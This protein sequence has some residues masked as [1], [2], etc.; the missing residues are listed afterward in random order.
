MPSS[1]MTNAARRVPEHRRRHA[2]GLGHLAVDVGQQR[3]GQA[4]VRGERLV[5]VEV[6]IGDPDDHRVERAHVV[7]AVAV[8]AELLG[9]D[10]G[11]VAGVEQ[12]HDPLARGARRAGSAPSVPSSVEVRGEVADVRCGG[13]GVKGYGSR[14]SSGSPSTPPPSPPR[15]ERELEALVAVSSPSRRR[16]RRRGGGRARRGAGARRGDDRARRRARRPITRPTCSS[17]LP[18]TG[19]AADPAAR[20]PR[21]RRR[22]RRAPA[23][24]PRRRAARRLG[25]DRHE[26]RR[27]ARAR[28]PARA[29]RA[30]RAT[31]PRSRCCSS[32]DEEWRVGAVRPRRAL[33]RLR[34]L[35]VLRGRRSWPTTATRPSSSRRKAAGTLSVH[36][37]RAQRALG[38]GA[39]HGRQRAAGAGRGRA[40]GRRPPRP[41]RPAAPD[42]GADRAAR[43]ATRST[44]CP[45]AASWSATCAPTAST[46][47][48]ACCDARPGRGRRRARWRPSSCA[49]GR[50]WTRARPPRPLLARRPAALGR[51]VVGA[52]RGGASDASH[53]AATI[54]LTVDG[55]GPRGGGAHAPHEYVLASSLRP[56]AEVALAVADAA[57]ACLDAAGSSG[58]SVEV[59]F[60]ERHHICRS[61]R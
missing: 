26:G 40:G 60:K 6:L 53:F 4:V 59:R 51:P 1:S 56:R 7:G 2:V 30:P 33:R 24:A 46:P 37:A 39:R 13:H 16:P 43:R 48:T 8:G 44:S 58:R 3:H 9:A 45:A 35:P 50:G 55:L 5:G 32:C 61:I 41:A 21:H 28:R 54:P 17:R 22:P 49:S 38:L 15:A 36:R 14:G 18:G 31:S 11:L 27:R 34:R 23:A 25:R 20:P 19:R 29:R 10:R 12:Q 52:G 47:S 42:R 57:L